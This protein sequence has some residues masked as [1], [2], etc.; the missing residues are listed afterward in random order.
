MARA[1]RIWRE[2][3]H[4]RDARGRFAKR[5]GAAWIKRA[6]AELTS[7]ADAGSTRS[8]SGRPQISRSA[9]AGVVLQAHADGG[10]P[11][12][13]RVPK[14]TVTPRPSPAGL[15]AFNAQRLPTP[16]KRAAPPVRNLAAFNAPD[17]KPA[18]TETRMSVGKLKAMRIKTS[19]FDES[20][21]DAI[22]ADMRRNGYRG[23]PIQVEETNRDT[24]VTDGH[25]RLAAAER[26]GIA[27]VPVR[28]FANTPEGRR[29]ANRAMADTEAAKEAGT[30]LQPVKRTPRPAPGAAAFRAQRAEE[31][32][33]QQAAMVAARTAPESA[34]VPGAADYASMRQH[35]LVSL[36]RQAG[37][38]HRNRSRT[39][40]ANDLAARDAEV[41]ASRKA[42]LNP[43]G[44]GTSVDTPRDSRNDSGMTSTT[45]ETDA[46]LRSILGNAVPGSVRAMDAQNELNARR[47]GVAPG[48][49][50]K[51]EDSPE[52]YNWA[53][54]MEEKARALQAKRDAEKAAAPAAPG[55]DTEHLKRPKA[56]KGDLVVVE[57][58]SSSYTIGKGSEEQTTVHV[59]VVTSTDRDGRVTGWSR[60]ADGSYPKKVSNREK[61]YKLEA[62]RVDVAAAIETAR[63]NPWPHNPEAKGKPFASLAEARAAVAPHLGDQ[64]A[65]LK[66]ARAESRGAASRRPT[67]EAKV[68]EAATA[69][70]EEKDYAKALRLIGEGEAADPG[71]KD[72]QGRGWNDFRTFV[73]ARRDQVAKQ[74]AERK[75]GPKESAADLAIGR[76]LYQRFASPDR[77]PF[78][79][80][81]S[82]AERDAA[83]QKA[84][85]EIAS[86]L[87]SGA[88]LDRTTLANRL[89]RA[90]GA[91]A[92]FKH[93]REAKRAEVVQARELIA[94]IEDPE[95]RKLQEKEILRRLEFEEETLISAI[96]R[97]ETDAAAARADLEKALGRGSDREKLIARRRGEAEDRARNIASDG[98]RSYGDTGAG[99]RIIAKFGIRP[100]SADL[101]AMSQRD[102]ED[103]QN[104]LIM[105]G[106]HQ[107]DLSK[108]VR[109]GLR[110]V[111]TS[112]LTP[113]QRQAWI[114]ATDAPSRALVHTMAARQ[115][116]DLAL[117]RLAALEAHQDRPSDAPELRAELDKAIAQ[118][119]ANLD[120]A[121][122]ELSTLEPEYQAN[123]DRVQ[124]AV[125]AVR[126]TAGL[127][128]TK[129]NTKTID[130]A[131]AKRI[132]SAG[133]TPQ[134]NPPA[135]PAPSTGTKLV[136]V[137]RKR[138]G[139][140]AKRAALA[141]P[142]AP[143]PVAPAP[144]YQT[145]Y[146]RL[147]D[148]RTERERIA[149]SL[150]NAEQIE[151]QRVRETEAARLRAEAR[152]NDIRPER[153][154]LAEQLQQDRA[155]DS[156][157]MRSGRR[158]PQRVARMKQI[159]DRIEEIDTEDRKAKIKGYRKG[160]KVKTTYGGETIEVEVVGKTKDGYLRVLLPNGK[161]GSL[162]PKFIEGE[163]PA[164]KA[165]AAQVV[166]PARARITPDA[167]RAASLEKARLEDEQQG[168][169]VR[170]GEP[171]PAATLKPGDR[172]EYSNTPVTILSG[173]T[174]TTD[175][176]GQKLMRFEARREDTGKEGAIL[177][178]PTGTAQRLEAA[179]V[180]RVDTP[181][182]SSHNGGMT[183]ATNTP[184][185]GETTLGVTES[186]RGRTT[187]V[188]LP[189][190]TTAQRTSKTMEYSHAVV[191]THDLRADAR[192]LRAQTEV[193]QRHADAYEAW[194]NA[195]ANLDDLV[196][197]PNGAGSVR[198]DR[199]GLINYNH[200]LP[201]FEAQ[202]NGRYRSG[203]VRY[204]PRP[205]AFVIT[206][207]QR[208]R[209]GGAFNYSDYE[210]YQNHRERLA[211]A[212]QSREKN[213]ARAA[214]LEAGPQYEYYVPRWSQRVDTA[215]AAIGSPEVNAPNTTYQVIGV[216]GVAKDNGKP[217]KKVPTAE[218]KAAAL[219]AKKADEK[220]RQAA[221]DRDFV[222]RT[223]AAVERAIDEGGDP[224]DALRS[225]TDKALR[226]MARAVGAKLPRKPQTASG[227]PAPLDTAE[228]RRLIV[229]AIRRGRPGK[230]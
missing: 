118:E 76:D 225:K 43:S 88:M 182:V 63:A 53:A 20:R 19:G 227:T 29:A 6:A 54:D 155:A 190:G 149:D 56:R 52:K 28:V 166:V 173:P 66:A 176:F 80:A 37:V 96:H 219:E 130:A 142:E 51:R 178:G 209:S 160:D 187:T 83:E 24:I 46:E 106:S 123:L 5:G 159:E 135:P 39:E 194:I 30:D 203:T 224:E 172:I 228:A 15:A 144:K 60:N 103:A 169:Q 132:A 207:S 195:G 211:D 220:A 180:S 67:S 129:L 120:S 112:A 107:D 108:V 81:P 148:G 38:P 119:R 115:R 93:Q 210:G 95:Y 201:G 125:N 161:R 122:G 127:K 212:R 49:L 177:F 193:E 153:E 23:G 205:G 10:R 131:Y 86:L 41:A 94:K 181:R 82:H 126:A 229:E 92:A 218:E 230:A 1:K 121:Q 158:N 69:M 85:D 179:S 55:A 62:E 79:Y 65:K 11:S 214:A 26:A 167:K 199:M 33:P 78:D 185:P 154:K 35:T 138:I 133:I 223:R 2:S 40:I 74:E 7:A 109:S 147:G 198:D 8:A 68:T 188:T 141:P 50:P 134:P 215:Y 18:M 90:E 36:A 97:Q 202:P 25:H 57:E 150:A 206:S 197:V 91:V 156:V 111:D 136:M 170:P 44:V 113:E 171:V 163:T 61:T 21:I 84:R 45:P 101:K 191:A 196:A 12:A 226:F 183:N 157:D 151:Q 186:S 128:P 124:A 175:K 77:T 98:G 204:E 75:A 14:A 152:A 217:V 104:E 184:K 64:T 221:S 13:V 189:D 3:Q 168:G 4:P 99:A 89:A 70:R 116:R 222:D 22:A 140:D 164:P 9:K 174:E 73:T 32:A 162:H 17:P 87:P 16:V 102:R 192:D 208:H 137:P 100:S 213:L 139:T 145:L 105:R 72:K 31:Q 216:G 71:Y 117:S 143:T 42:K 200:Y 165:D 47:L 146:Q 114:D 27:D 59:G 48:A 110:N 58:T 34:P